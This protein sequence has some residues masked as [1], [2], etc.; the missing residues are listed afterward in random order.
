MKLNQKMKKIFDI[1]K[2]AK[3]AYEDDPIIKKKT[4]SDKIKLKNLD[5]N[6]KPIEIDKKDFQGITIIRKGLW[7]H[8]VSGLNTKEIIWRY[9]KGGPIV[10]HLKFGMPIEE[11]VLRINLLFNFI[12]RHAHGCLMFDPFDQAEGRKKQIIV[13]H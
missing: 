6:G 7:V 13:K 4:N 5:P 11:L 12:E 10:L 3:H 2:V 1:T 8:R 9:Q